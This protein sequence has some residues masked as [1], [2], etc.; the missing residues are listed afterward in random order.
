MKKLNKNNITDILPLTP[1]QEGMLWHDLRN[2]DSDRYFEQLCIEVSGIV[3]V[4]QFEQAWQHVIENNEM[5][6]TIYRWEKVEYPIQIVLKKNNFKSRYFDLSGE[7]YKKKKLDDIK[8]RQ[9]QEKFNLTKTCFRVTLCKLETDKFTIIINNHHICFDGWSSGIIL[10]EFFHA[11]ND[12]SQGRPLKPRGKTKFKEF[13]KWLHDQDKTRQKA[14]WNEY[15]KGFNP[16]KSKSILPCMGIG[17]GEMENFKIQWPE[18]FVKK[19]N[20]IVLKYKITSAALFNCTWGILL[21]KYLD[22]EDI[23]FGTTVSGRNAKIKGT[24]NMVGLFINT[25]PLRMQL[26][27]YKKTIELLKDVHQ[28]MQSREKYTHTSLVDIKSWSR[29]DFNQNLF[30]SIVVIEN[31]PLDQI[32]TDKNNALS[33][34]SYSIFVQA[35]FDL[36]VSISMHPGVEIIF[37][38]TK[39]LFSFDT[40]ERIALHFKKIIHFILENP[41]KKDRRI[42]DIEIITTKE[43]ETI[44]FEFNQTSASF[45]QGKA[46]HRL[47]EEQ[48]EQTPVYIALIDLSTCGGLLS[49]E[50]I[51]MKQDSHFTYKKLNEKS[52]QLACVLRKKGAGSG[53]IIGILMDSTIEMAI[54]LLGILK[55][56]SAYLPIDPG[57]P[58]ERIDFML[59]DS[60]MRILVT[61][62]PG[63]FVENSQFSIVNVQEEITNS[64][65]GNFPLERGASAT[66]LKRYGG[67]GGHPNPQ[68]SFLTRSS[69]LAYI[70]YTS[71]TTGRPKGVPLQ[72]RS[73]VNTL[74]Y[75]KEEYG[76][77]SQTTVL[78]LFSYAFDGFVTSFFTPVISGAK[79]ILLPGEKVKDIIFLKKTIAKHQVNQFISVPSLYRTL[80]EDADSKEL[81]SLKLVILAG[82]RVLPNILDLTRQK[83]KNLEISI[84]YGVTEAAVMS[85]IYRHQ[86]KR[87]YIM[88]GHP[89][90]NVKIYIIDG[91]ENMQPIGIPGEMCIAGLGVA[92]GYLNNPELTNTKFFWRGQGTLMFEDTMINSFNIEHAF[93]NFICTGNIH[94]TPQVKK[95]PIN[96]EMAQTYQRSY[97]T[98]DLARWSGDGNIEFLGRKDHQ[99]KIR[100]YRIEPGEIETR[101]LKQKNIKDTVVIS[102]LDSNGD[103]YLIAYIVP[104]STRDNGTQIPF[105]VLREKLSKELPGYMIP[106]YFVQLKKIPLTPNGKVDRDAL[107]VVDTTSTVE[108]AAPRDALEEKL[109]RIWT[110]V[111]AK[112]NIGIDDNF[113]YLGGHSLKATL[114]FSKVHKKLGVKIPLNKIFEM[115]TIRTLSRYIKKLN[116]EKYQSIE[117][118]E[119]KE[120]YPLSPAQKR[121]FILQQMETDYINYNISETFLLEGEMDKDRFEQTLKQSILRHE[122]F[123]T[124]F[125]MM[126]K[127]PVQKVHKEV[128]FEIEYDHSSINGHWSSVN[129]LGRSGDSLPDLVRKINGEFIRPFDLSLAPLLRVGIVGP[130]RTSSSLNSHFCQAPYDSHEG[131]KGKYFLMVDMHHII[132]DGTSIGIIIKEFMS[133]YEGKD[134]PALKIRYKDYADWKQKKTQ[135]K[136]IKKQ[137]AFWLDQFK[138]DIPIL[139]IPADFPQSSQK[140]YEGSVLS[141]EFNR[142]VTGLI[143]ALAD[144]EDVTLFMMLLALFNILLWKVSRTESIIVGTPTAGRDNADLE[145]I[146]GMFVHTL[147]LK[148][149]P[150]GY[151][152]FSSFLKEIKENTLNAF[153]NQ[154]YPFEYLVEEVKVSRDKVRNPIFNVMFALQ[155]MEISEI[156]I[157][158]LTITP[159]DYYSDIAMFDLSLFAQEKR[160]RLTFKLGY[161]SRLFRKETVES[162]FRYFREIAK[163]VINNKN[164]LLKEIEISHRLVDPESNY[165]SEVE[166]DFGF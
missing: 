138:D 161:A 124:S 30:D 19:M 75:R 1:M 71:G 129:C 93:D 42:G 59:A 47:F 54:S 108:Y 118:V 120:Y 78:Q 162:F 18:D 81:A 91:R 37:S 31:Y 106:G 12:L 32:L 139:D 33:I 49:T 67:G 157:P 166:G 142:E 152:T 35:G 15:L 112:K 41:E 117:S 105:A 2:P 123:R 102:R 60:N 160:N 3:K 133:F 119:E 48:V 16:A 126:K 132:T 34:H 111:L 77:N 70:I 79:V 39:K 20:H 58:E 74:S 57:Y 95:P 131:K 148:N 145:G 13:V 103:Y 90:Q 163:G 122:S 156:T 130:L 150:R 46:I 92:C 155:N 97:K 104:Y 22:N 98:G 165:L 153:E 36:M 55:T 26:Y 144:A 82:D 164:A 66:A 14:F 52:D 84:E 24:E 43:R 101:L 68:E 29:I 65:Q 6:R 25:L 62:F 125:H 135:K 96:R 7:F 121:L 11:Y 154:D 51:A 56:G 27:S 87:Q 128:Q 53:T 69:Q 72:H 116:Q 158:G 10:E 127:E 45:P 23:L 137:G 110:E 88:I 146:I 76:L 115:M 159:C 38:Y 5:L 100:G 107:S 85:T 9:R 136:K 140:G 113:F 40:I 86:E 89:I 83:N 61:N 80:L 17:K 28:S 73:V 147:A 134:L 64:A 99:V 63:K 149:E 109:I 94:L 4:D 8:N 151:K 44:L 143:K 50:S 21:W 114:L 141:F